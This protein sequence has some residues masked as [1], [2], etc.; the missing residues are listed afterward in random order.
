[1]PLGWSLE[2]TKKK[3]K[4]MYKRLPYMTFKKL[5]SMFEFVTSN[6]VQH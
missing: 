6:M 1:M 2:K 4:K 5:L 3:K